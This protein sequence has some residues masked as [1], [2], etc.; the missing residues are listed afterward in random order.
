[1]QFAVRF[2]PQR[3]RATAQIASLCVQTNLPAKAGLPVASRNPFK[4]FE[5]HRMPCDMRVVMLLDD[6]PSKVLIFRDI[7]LAVKEEVVV[8][9]GP[10]CASN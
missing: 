5:S 3:L 10:F 8:L 7:D 2:M 9:K 4:G 1:M 6:S